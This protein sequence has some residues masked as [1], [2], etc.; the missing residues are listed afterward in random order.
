M[1]DEKFFLGR[2]PILDRQQNLFGYELL[3]RSADTSSVVVTDY[4]YASASVISSAMANFGFREVLGRHRG[5]INVDTDVLMSD[6]LELLPKEQVV[7]ELLEVIDVNTAVIERCRELKSKGFCL[8]LDDHV[9]APVYKPLYGI[10]DIIKVDLTL[11]TPDALP[12]IVRQLKGLPPRL[13]AEKVETLEQFDQCRSLGFEFF[14]GY[15][16]ARPIVLKNKR[17]DIGDSCLVRLQQLLLKDAEIGV[18]EESFRESPKLVFN[19]LRL[20]N[21]IAM[22]LVDKIRTV[23][24]AIVILGRRQLLRWTYLAMFASADTR[25]GS[26]TLLELAAMRGRW[27]ELI[28]Q[29]HISRYRSNDF[30]ECAFITGILSLADQLFEVPMEQLVGHFNLDEDVSRALIKREGVLGMLLR[31]VELIELGDYAAAL[32]ILAQLEIS[33]DQLL[34]FQ[35]EAINWTNSLNDQV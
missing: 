1:V 9:Y 2:Q 30:H 19:L 5:F 20:V 35:L 13:L 18:I 24:H 33:Q 22:G 16:L 21:S 14:Q 4:T 17:I 26:G 25:P 6:A 27:M 10:I 12:G 11:S 7:L 32:P 23:R 29:R 3:F 28:I 8:A 31:L 34:T 15:F